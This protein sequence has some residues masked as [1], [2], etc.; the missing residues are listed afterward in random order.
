MSL[1]QGADVAPTT[2]G[3]AAAADRA[4]ALAE[5]M[6]RWDALRGETLTALNALLEQAGLPPIVVKTPR[7]KVEREGP[8]DF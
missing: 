7:E 3:A 2:Q 1:L 5:V 4:E 8:D 6:S